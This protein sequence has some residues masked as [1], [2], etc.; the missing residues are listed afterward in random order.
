MGNFVG[1]F[2]VVLGLYPAHPHLAV[3][4]SLGFVFSTAYALRMMQRIFFGEN[5][6]G[7]KVPDLT[8]RE[9]GVMSLMMVPLLW[10][11]L[12]PQPFIDRVQKS[13]PSMHEAAAGPHTEIKP[14]TPLTPWRRK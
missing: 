4:A 13:S 6:G 2:M 14:A 5:T 10:L 12:S 1:E 8:M 9:M 3:A 7:W 11:G